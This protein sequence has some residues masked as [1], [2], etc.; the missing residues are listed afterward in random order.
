MNA[1]KQSSPERPLRVKLALWILYL[2]LGITVTRLLFSPRLGFEDSFPPEY[3]PAT[4]LIALVVSSLFR[5]LAWMRL[6]GILI[7]PLAAWLYYM[8]GKGK[9]W[10]RKTL[11]IFVLMDALACILSVFLLG[12]AYFDQT[13][14][15][16]SGSLIHGFPPVLQLVLRIAAVKLVYG[17]VSSDWFKA[18]NSGSY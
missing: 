16:L 5:G 6:E 1:G 11:L 2:S 7:V 9:N 12:Y 8:I 15:T 17:R 14:P 3:F 18:M 4:I 10:A 13:P